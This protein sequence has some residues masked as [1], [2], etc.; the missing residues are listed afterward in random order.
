M[1]GV[2]D[3][4]LGREVARGTAVADFMAAVG[5]GTGLSYLE[6]P[7]REWH[8]VSGVAEDDAGIAYEYPEGI[9]GERYVELRY[10]LRSIDRELGTMSVGDDGVHPGVDHCIELEV[11]TATLIDQLETATFSAERTRVE[12]IDELRSLVT[13]V[14]ARRRALEHPTAETENTSIEDATAAVHHREESLRLSKRSERTLFAKCDAL[15]DEDRNMFSTTLADDLEPFAGS[16][17]QLEQLYE[18]HVELL[19]QLR[20]TY[21]AA[22]LPEEEWICSVD[23]HGESR[24]GDIDLDRALDILWAYLEDKPNGLGTVDYDKVSARWHRDYWNV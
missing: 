12:M 6:V 13:V 18:N 17:G 4:E 19:R 5:K 1:F 23:K 16:G 2:D 24:E 9:D 8:E 15:I 21:R 3:I 10:E 14:S 20:A 7:L 22:Q 11:K